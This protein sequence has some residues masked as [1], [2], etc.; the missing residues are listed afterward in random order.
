MKATAK[1]TWARPTSDGS[2]LSAKAT[3]TA[4]AKDATS[5][6]TCGPNRNDRADD[7]IDGSGIPEAP[8][9]LRWSPMPL[10]GP[11]KSKQECGGGYQRYTLNHW[12]CDL[13]DLCV[14]HRLSISRP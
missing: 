10:V 9:S 6:K 7:V 3:P 14:D 12:L 1:A 5:S 13:C 8:P 11:T 2:A 4:A